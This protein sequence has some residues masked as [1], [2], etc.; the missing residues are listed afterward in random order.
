MFKIF[1]SFDI[2]MKLMFLK[3]YDGEGGGGGDGSGDGN[4]TGNGDGDGNGSG[5]PGG[6]DGKS[7]GD[8]WQSTLPEDVQGWNEVKEAKDPEAFWNLLTNMRG[9]V[10]NS[11]RI[12]GEDA[13]DEAR[14]AFHKKL[15]DKVPGLMKSPDKTSEEDMK[16]LY[17]SLGLPAK[18]EDYKYDLGEKNKDGKLDT[19]LIETFRAI[20]HRN[21]L[22]EKQFDN[23]VNGITDVNIA[24]AATTLGMVKANQD[25]LKET[26]GAAHAQN[27][28][29]VGVFAEKTN[30]PPS[31][32]AAVKDGIMDQASMEWIHSMAVALGPEG[33]GIAMDK[34][35]APG[36]LTPTEAKAQIS[37]IMN[38]SKHDYWNTASLG[39]KDART[40]MRTLRL[41]EVGETDKGSKEVAK[42]ASV[43]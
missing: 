23:I 18:P 13:S 19:S 43:V 20:A 28:E 6:G 9:M 8:T 11:I 21:G 14:T 10:G 16:A 32:Q 5:D 12:P 34:T 2:F 26:W 3:F 29:M 17:T 39:H 25:A 4:G 40:K 42:R 37:E 27:T 38:N 22:S 24:K 7:D 15:T 31:I 35:T 1:R 33:S 30:A 41:A 36:V